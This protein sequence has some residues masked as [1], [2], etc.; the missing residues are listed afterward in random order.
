MLCTSGASCRSSGRSVVVGVG[1]AASDPVSVVVEGTQ[2]EHTRVHG[3][4]VGGAASY[5]EASGALEPDRLVG[6]RIGRG[7]QPRLDLARVPAGLGLG[8]DRGRACD[9]RRGH[10]RAAQRRVL[11]VNQVA[12]RGSVGPRGHDVDTGCHDL[13]LHPECAAGDQPAGRE[14]RSSVPL[15]NRPDGQRQVGG[16]GSGDAALIGTGVAGG[17]DEQGAGLAA[18]PVDGLA[19]R[20]AAVG[21]G[22]RTEAH[23]DHLGAAAGSPLHPSDDLVARPRA[24][25]VEHLA[26]HQ[27][28]AGCDAGPQ[29]VGALAATADGRRHVGAVAVV[30][31][32]RGLALG[33]GKVSGL[34]Y[35]SLEVR[36]FGVVAG[37]E[38][39][40]L[41]AGPVEASGP[42]RRSPDSTDAVVEARVDW[43]VEPQGRARRQLCLMPRPGGAGSAQRGPHRRGVVLRDA[44]RHHPHAGQGPLPAR[45]RGH[46]GDAAASCRPIAL[47]QQ[48]PVLPGL[49]VEP[50][51]HQQGDVEQV[52]VEDSAVNVG[53]R[54]VGHQ[55]HLPVLLIDEW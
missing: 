12:Q 36:V 39:R 19:Q 17:D 45:P 47:H 30:V 26:D 22:R 51:L 41:R 27:V 3:D 28:G 37:V 46:R 35:A 21:G 40:H 20:V 25:R 18:Q 33:A 15:V 43:G 4:R 54:L 10:G 29:A 42:G 52:G 16:A 53:L 38:H 48:R 8:D 11:R 55:V 7:H 2:G 50:L 44:H 49:V 14:R 23:V 24:A 9:V 13:G 32:C 1:Q 6:E 5:V 31:A 34:R